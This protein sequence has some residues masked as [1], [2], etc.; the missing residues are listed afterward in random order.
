MTYPVADLITP[1]FPGEHL[2]SRPMIG[3]GELGN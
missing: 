3:F 2:L 1:Q